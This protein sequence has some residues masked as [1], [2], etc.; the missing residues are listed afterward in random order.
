MFYVGY[1]HAK[2][3]KWSMDFLCDDFKNFLYNMLLLIVWHPLLP[4][5]LPFSIHMNHVH[6]VSVHIIM[7]TIVHHLDNFVNKWTP[8]AP[9]RSLNQIQFL[10]PVLEL[11]FCWL[12]ATWF[13]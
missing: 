5:T 2:E 7:L 3:W 12:G 6:I 13:Q 11:P 4:T 8:N 1:L 9:A 10:Q